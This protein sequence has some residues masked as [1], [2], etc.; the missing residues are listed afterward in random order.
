MPSRP[1]SSANPGPGR[2]RTGGSGNG[3]SSASRNGHGRTPRNGSGAPRSGQPSRSSR[4]TRSTTRVSTPIA[5]AQVSSARAKLTGRAAVLLL[6]VAV[7]AVSYASSM[8]A[9]LK[10][11]SDINTLNAQIAGQRADVAAL[12]EAKGRLHDPA[13][14]ESE[15]RKRFGWILPGETGYRVIGDNGEVLSDGGSVLSDPTAPAKP[16]PEWWQD[17]YGSVQQAGKEPAASPK[18]QG[19]T[20]PQ[21]TPP[22]GSGRPTNR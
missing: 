22:A 9:W 2:G 12:R 5:T 13:Y 4:S 10:Q 18:K 6:V 16:D 7:L 11:R 21:R 19:S 14:I 20:T 1:G 8:R 17:M 15:A 3:R